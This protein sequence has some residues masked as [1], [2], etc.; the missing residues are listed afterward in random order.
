MPTIQEILKKYNVKPGELSANFSIPLRTVYAWL[1]EERT[2]PE[3]VIKMICELMEFRK[4]GKT[5]IFKR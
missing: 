4:D 5:D 1:S 2:P 3:Y